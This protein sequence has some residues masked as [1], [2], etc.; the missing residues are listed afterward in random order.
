[1]NIIYKDI[2]DK[3]YNNSLSKGDRLIERKISE[4]FGVNR[5]HVKKALQKLEDDNL[6]LYTPKKGYSVIGISKKYFLEIA[7]LREVLEKTIIKDVIKNSSQ[8]NIDLLANSA[9]RKAIFLENNLVEDAFK[10]TKFFF[11]NLYNFSS[12]DIIINLLVEY[13]NLIETMTKI[14]FESSEGLQKSIKNSRFLQKAL[15]K[16]DLI[17]LDEWIHTRYKNI[18]ETINEESQMSNE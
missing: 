10:E 9:L 11:E 18:C 8:E 6:V 1:M 3:I 16:K 2:K 5:I 13:N 15:I 12:Y 7:K 14:T 17:L 4:T